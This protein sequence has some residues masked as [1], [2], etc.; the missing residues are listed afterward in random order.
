MRRWLI[1][2]VSATLGS[3]CAAGLAACGEDREG[4]VQVETGRTATG[5]TSPAA[6]GAS[7]STQ[8][9]TETQP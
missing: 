7:T 9:A 3:S 4:G 2:I 8:P 5:S 6:P 1:V